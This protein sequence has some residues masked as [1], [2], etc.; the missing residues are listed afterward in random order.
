MKIINGFV[1]RFKIKN[2]KCNSFSFNKGDLSNRD[3][4]KQ[5]NADTNIMVVPLMIV[6]L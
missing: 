3:L 5:L 6:L 1:K 4:S 2:R